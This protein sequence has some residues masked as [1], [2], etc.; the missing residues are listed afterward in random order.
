MRRQRHRITAAVA[1]ALLAA[2]VPA[3]S[4]ADGDSTDPRLPRVVNAPGTWSDEDELTGPVAALGLA[5]RTRPVGFNG[6]REQLAMFGVSATDQ[7]SAWVRLPR[8]DMNERPLVDRF[9]LSPDGRWIGWTRRQHPQRP[10]IERQARWAGNT[11]LTGWA[12]MDTT[13]GTVRTFSDP[14]HPLL[15][16]TMAPLAFSGD[17]RYLL[18]TYESPDAPPRRG[19]RFVAFSVADGSATTLE[20]PGH[21]WHPVVGSAPTGVVWA[22]RDTVFRADPAT[23]HRSRH[24]L[25]HWV[26]SASW[27]PD[28]TAFAYVG[29]PL[30]GRPGP[31]RLYAG[32]SLAQARD[33]HLPLPVDP[34]GVLGWRDERHVVVGHHRRDV[35]VVDVVTG[36][37]TE[38]DLAGHGEPLN[39]P[40]LAADLWVHP[41]A[42]P[43]PPD[44]T[45]DPRR[46][47][48]YAAGAGLATSV[49]GG[50]L[51]VRR[52]RKRHTGVDG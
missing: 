42:D 29:R 22:R 20:E 18:A 11:I 40:L 46:P 36:E 16:D 8:V 12:V 34:G 23:G 45:T 27:G 48:Q 17:S 32:P 1:A 6:S 4:Q 38:L 2:L 13:T 28:D 41:M 50:L 51:L 24:R 39:A 3:A 25:P 44:G 15:R 33:R 35:H 14:T 52:G 7:S 49:I 37:V 10:G 47:L 19:H 5:M 21:Y 26:V 43:P 31:W 9:A 30:R